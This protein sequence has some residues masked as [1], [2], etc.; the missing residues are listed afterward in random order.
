MDYGQLP[1]SAA[2]YPHMSESKGKGRA[3]RIRRSSGFWIPRVD[4][5]VLY[6]LLS[7]NNHRVTKVAYH[8]V[9]PVKRHPPSLPETSAAAPL[10]G[11]TRLAKP[12]CLECFPIHRSEGNLPT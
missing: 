10:A 5:D 9:A 4:A 2:L 1:N 6:R 3:R 12:A 7:S 8:D 11:N